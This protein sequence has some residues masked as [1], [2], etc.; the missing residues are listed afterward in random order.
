MCGVSFL[1]QKNDKIKV[2]ELGGSTPQLNIQ[3]NV[4]GRGEVKNTL[5]LYHDSES[6]KTLSYEVHPR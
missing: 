3:I 5:F 4:Y 1:L 6:C 2:R